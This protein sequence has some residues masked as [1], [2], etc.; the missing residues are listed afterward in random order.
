M[1]RFKSKNRVFLR[2]YI[3]NLSFLLCCLVFSIWL[4][5]VYDIDIVSNAFKHIVS[6]ILF[7][8]LAFDLLSFKS[9][10][11]IAKNYFV[12]LLDKH[13]LV[14]KV[15]LMYEDLSILKVKRVNGAV[16]RIFLKTSFNQKIQLCD[17]ENMDKLLE[18][19]EEKIGYNNGQREK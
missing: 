19:L 16:E 6:S 9:S 10:S 17:L 15:R 5:Y 12:Q 11:E 13:M 1:R 14:Y 8:W 4:F 18:I 3:R 2:N 7:L